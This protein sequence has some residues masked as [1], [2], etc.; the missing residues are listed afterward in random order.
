MTG[1]VDGIEHDDGILLHAQAG[2]GV[3]PVALPT[4]GSQARMNVL[5]VIAA[6]GADEQRQ[7]GQRGDRSLASCTLAAPA[8]AAAQ[9]QRGAGSPACEVLKKV[10]ATCSKSRSSRILSRST[11]PTMPRQPMMPICFMQSDQ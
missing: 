6:L 9:V 1:K 7:P 8:G 10:G 3:D 2:R 11:E 4:G 5:G